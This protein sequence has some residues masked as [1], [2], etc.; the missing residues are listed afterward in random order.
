MLNTAIKKME[1]FS[2][3]KGFTMIEVLIAMTIFLIGFL[4]VGTMQ[5]SSMNGNASARMRTEATAIAA[6]HAERILAMDFAD[7]DA[8]LAVYPI[9]QG[10]YTINTPQITSRAD[11]PVLSAANNKTINITVQW[12]KRGKDNSVTFSLMAVDM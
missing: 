7:I 4:A 5:I 9:V 11:T 6:Q 12:N 2:D 8:S 3:S 10:P 1:P